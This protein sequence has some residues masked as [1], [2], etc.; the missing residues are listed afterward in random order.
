MGEDG[1][2]GIMVLRGSREVDGV[3]GGRCDCGLAVLVRKGLL[4]LKFWDGATFAK[5][6]VWGL[7]LLI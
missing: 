3:G 6:E 2:C 5:H 7:T 1:S 4:T